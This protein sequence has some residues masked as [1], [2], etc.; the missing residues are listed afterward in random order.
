[1]KT[2]SAMTVALVLLLS[3]AVGFAA[4]AT[5]QWEAPV[6]DATHG[7]ATGF[8][9]YKGTG[10]VCSQTGP[11]TGLMS[12]LGYVLAATDTTITAGQTVCYEISGTN[13]GGEGPHSLRVTGLVPVNPP[14]APLNP[15][16]SV[17]P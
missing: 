6:A 16:L 3:A 10:S 11:L 12:T 7:A 13:A 1:M 8:K 15:R 4:T 5:L 9:V 14:L 17:A 2:L